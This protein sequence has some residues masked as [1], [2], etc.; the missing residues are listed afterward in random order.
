MQWKNYARVYLCGLVVLVLCDFAVAQTN[1]T[2]TCRYEGFFEE[3]K[4]GYKRKRILGEEVNISDF[5]DCNC[6]NKT[7]TTCSN[8]GVN[9]VESTVGITF[10]LFF[11]LILGSACLM[12]FRKLKIQGVLETPQAIALE[13]KRQQKEG[14][15][16]IITEY[17]SGPRIILV[18]F[19]SDGKFA[20]SFESKNGTVIAEHDCYGGM[21]NS[22]IDYL[23]QNSWSLELKMN[24]FITSIV[25]ETG[26][27]Y[28][29][30]KLTTNL[31]ERTERKYHLFQSRTRNPNEKISNSTVFA[32]PPGFMISSFEC[33]DNQITKAVA[34]PVHM[35]F[36]STVEVGG[37]W[38]KNFCRSK[39]FV[40]SCL[41]ELVVIV[42]DF[43]SLY[44][45]F[46]A[47]GGNSEGTLGY[48]HIAQVRPIQDCILQWKEVVQPCLAQGHD[49]CLKARLKSKTEITFRAFADV[50]ST[51]SAGR[52][53]TS[54]GSGTACSECLLQRNRTKGCFVKDVVV[55]Y[56]YQRIHGKGYSL[57][58]WNIE[59]DH[60]YCL[61]NATPYSTFDAFTMLMLWKLMHISLEIGMVIYEIN[62]HRG[63][64]HEISS[65]HLK[66][67]KTSKI[68]KLIKSGWRSALGFFLSTPANYMYASMLTVGAPITASSTVGIETFKGPG[69]WEAGSTLFI[70]AS[71]YTLWLFLPIGT[72]IFLPFALAPSSMYLSLC[73][74]KCA[75]RKLY[76]SQ[77][78]YLGALRLRYHFARRIGTFVLKGVGGLLMLP[79]TIFF[80]LALVDSFSKSVVT[81]G[82]LFFSCTFTLDVNLSVPS[83]DAVGRAVFVASTTFI[84]AL[85]RYVVLV[86]HVRPKSVSALCQCIGKVLSTKQIQTARVITK[87]VELTEAHGEV[88][89]KLGSKTPS[90]LRGSTE[91]YNGA[92]GDVGGV[93]AAANEQFG[94]QIIESEQGTIFIQDE[95]SQFKDRYLKRLDSRNDDTGE[96]KKRFM[97]VMLR[98][99][100]TSPI[101]V[102]AL[103]PQKQYPLS[104]RTVHYNSPNGIIAARIPDDI[105]STME[106][107][108]VLV[109]IKLMNDKVVEFKPIPSV[110][111]KFPDGNREEIVVL[112]G[113]PDRTNESFIG[114]ADEVKK[115]TGL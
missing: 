36:N 12:A 13:F 6:C 21:S 44:T 72:F 31:T 8:R 14:K 105:R 89:G 25:Q 71:S 41:V 27:K 28:L 106:D 90:G 99:C 83:F 108:N 97:D 48:L 19:L 39:K 80:V 77:K 9:S 7:C 114:D 34:M 115:I 11:S 93:A 30:I 4:G 79:L 18:T 38:K 61:S 88:L 26:D 22:G 52:C 104:R 53:Y 46:I 35:V 69:I 87:V 107:Q 66:N 10:Y 76:S 84:A 55:M 101:Y 68:R 47:F 32:C 3:V 2:N 62:V 86:F 82:S 100:C 17:H 67:V 95:A 73:W 91:K 103:T 57:S 85:G 102:V 65:L 5:V 15:I 96:L 113:E 109:R 110:K 29:A 45:L 43:I 59:S 40:I 24:E 54:S 42:L 51:T 98:K 16:E 74:P 60:E 49:D 50:E 81:F 1:R 37:A 23:C 75:T 94:K 33:E 56:P 64:A 92:D 111:I 78:T 112:G 58:K 70:T 63:A 20:M